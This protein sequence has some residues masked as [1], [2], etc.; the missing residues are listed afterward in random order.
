MLQYF[1]Y[2]NKTI[3]YLFY[4]YSYDVNN[5]III[6]KYIY[7]RIYKY[8]WRFETIYLMKKYTVNLLCF[9]NW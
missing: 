3:F 4:I 6:C 7:R 1:E 8:I 2:G 5:E 9:K